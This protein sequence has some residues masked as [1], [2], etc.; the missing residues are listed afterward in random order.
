[1][2]ESCILRTDR[3]NNKLNRILFKNRYVVRKSM[4]LAL[5]EPNVNLNALIVPKSDNQNVG[6]Y[7]QLKLLIYVYALYVG[8]KLTVGENT[9]LICHWIN[10]SGVSGCD[11]LGVRV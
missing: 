8:Y 2:M 3:Q 4:C 9:T 10:S 7:Y 11:H 6:D 1:M 5:S